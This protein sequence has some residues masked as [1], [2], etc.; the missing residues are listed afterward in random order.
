MKQ[1]TYEEVRKSLAIV[2]GEDDEYYNTEDEEDRAAMFDRV[3]DAIDNFIEQPKP[4][5]WEEV[6]KA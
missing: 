3:V 6:V 1:V 4:S 2:Y 5:T